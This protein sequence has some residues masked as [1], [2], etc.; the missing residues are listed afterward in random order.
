MRKN[1]LPKSRDPLYLVEREFPRNVV[2][3]AFSNFDT[4]EDYKASCEQTYI[5][6]GWEKGS[7]GFKITITPYYG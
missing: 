7:F 3:A 4:A 2:V 1:S 5:D 6:A